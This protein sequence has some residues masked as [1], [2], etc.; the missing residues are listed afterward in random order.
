MNT[1]TNITKKEEQLLSDFFSESLSDKDKDLFLH[2][3]ASDK[4]FIKEF[5]HL[6]SKL[7]S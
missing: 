3:A 2:K 1:S 4:N 6:L 7:D 5:V